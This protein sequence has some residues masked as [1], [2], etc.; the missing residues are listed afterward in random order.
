MLDPR[1]F[2]AQHPQGTRYAIP[3]TLWYVSGGKD[4]QEPPEQP[5]E[6]HEAVR[7]G[8]RDQPT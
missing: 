2:F 7:R 3:W 4:G 8:A 6:A 1:D 5:E